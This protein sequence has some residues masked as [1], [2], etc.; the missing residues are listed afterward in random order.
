M[1]SMSAITRD[2]A[3]KVIR[4][5][6][7]IISNSNV[8]GAS[9]GVTQN[10]ANACY[11]LFSQLWQ[12]GD[13][14]VQASDDDMTVNGITVDG[15]NPVLKAFCD[16][17]QDRGISN[18]LLKPDM[19]R[20][21]F[22]ALIEIL[23]AKPDEL[24]QLGAF[25]GA[26][27]TLG[28]ADVIISRNVT[29]V[30]VGEDEIVIDKQAAIAAENAKKAATE[31]NQTAYAAAYLTGDTSVDAAGA[32]EGLKKIGGDAKALSSLI[33][34]SAKAD[35]AHDDEMA[36]AIVDCLHRLYAALTSDPSFNTQK[37]KKQIHKTLVKL[38]KELLEQLKRGDG[39]G[40]SASEDEI[41]AIRDTIETMED[42]L[43]IDTLSQEYTKKRSA[44]GNSEKRL[45]RYI[46]NKGVDQIEESD[47][48]SR[49]ID[50]GLDPEDWEELLSK[51]GIM[52]EVHEPS[53]EPHHSLGTGD[54][55]ALLQKIEADVGSPDQP[56]TA[57]SEGGFDQ[58][59]RDTSGTRAVML[60]VPE[61]VLEQDLHAVHD[62]VNRIILKAEKRIE[63]LVKEV[64]GGK[65]SDDQDGE[66]PPK[67]TQNRL[68]E[69]LAELGQELCQ[70]L[71]VISCS[72]DALRSGSLGD[73]NKI[74][75]EMLDMSSD[76]ADKLKQLIDKIIAISGVPKD[77]VVNKDIQSSLYQ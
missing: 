17:L 64:K 38:E 29:Y 39:D 77:L 48:K 23:L 47:L 60:R 3:E 41:Q 54:L 58:P 50:G 24:Q 16:H 9:H 53:A 70:P 43:T 14:S 73:I 66:K 61:A 55:N 18:F 57:P 11:E 49:L 30:E 45:L 72:V 1:E 13:I 26:I 59:K 8:Y 25:N 35:D 32:S 10:A 37:T 68:F 36:R 4:A 6:G 21:Q 31:E 40:Q 42:E 7:L 33:L 2:T 65:E 27:A 46:R 19:T 5:L 28:L 67:L 71:A 76:S 12:E 63:E 62:E 20:E 34:E 74:Q 56:S 44:I 51:S 22:S 15:K 69:L 75:R 52:N